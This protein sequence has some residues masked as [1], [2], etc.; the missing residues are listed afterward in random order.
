MRAGLEQALVRG[1]VRIVAPRAIG[2]FHGKALVGLLERFFGGVVAR[3]AQWPFGFDQEIRL[4][5]T[6]GEVADPAPLFFQG[7]VDHRPFEGFA[8][9]T[10]EAGFG[11]V[12]FQEVLARRPM[13]IMTN[14]A[15]FRL[16]GSVDHRLVEPEAFWIVTGQ[17]EIRPFLFQKKFGNDAVPE[18]AIFAS[19]FADT[20]VKPGE[21]LEFSAKGLM[22]IQ[23]FLFLELSGFRA[24]G[25]PWTNHQP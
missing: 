10:L 6:V 18:V 13:R 11:T 21:P 3:E 5:R 7:G 20:G 15:L 22:A 2:F 4:S 8:V 25:N 12:R 1:G 23:A 9:V 14:H 17:A 16:Q 24:D 19:T